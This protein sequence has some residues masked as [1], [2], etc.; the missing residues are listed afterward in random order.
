MGCS[1]GHYRGCTATGSAGAEVPTAA[2]PAATAPAASKAD[3]WACQN[4]QKSDCSPRNLERDVELF[5]ITCKY[6]RRSLT[7]EGVAKNAAQRDLLVVTIVL[8]RDFAPIGFDTHRLLIPH[9]VF[10]SGLRMTSR[11]CFYE[12]R[13]AGLIL[14]THAIRS[15]T[16]IGEKS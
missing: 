15:G 16:G 6:V 11:I 5:Q 2:A 10:R 3:E 8:D 4:C 9:A 14:V 1:V 12:R 13:P 7:T